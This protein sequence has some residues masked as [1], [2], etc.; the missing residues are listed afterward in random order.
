MISENILGN[1]VNQWLME[2]EHVWDMPRPVYKS[3]VEWFFFS[4][5]CQMTLKVK[6][7]AS[8][9]QY[10]LIESQDAYLVEIWWF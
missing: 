1:H 8:H 10:Q 7:N 3:N 9:F 2:Q 4:K 5:N 6:V